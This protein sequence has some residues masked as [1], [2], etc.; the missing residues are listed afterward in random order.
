MTIKTTDEHWVEM[1]TRKE[2][3]WLI[4][5]F[6]GKTPA[7]LYAD[8]KVGKTHMAVNMVAALLDGA[9]TFLDTQAV[10]GPVQCLYVALDRGGE[11]EIT[12][13]LREL[14]SRPALVTGTLDEAELIGAVKAH[15]VGFVV[16]DNVARIL[17]GLNDFND[18]GSIGPLTAL[19][20]NLEDAGASVL[21]IHHTSK[22][23]KETPQSGRS[24]SGTYA[25]MAYF[26]Q[27]IEMTPK[28]ITVKSN[29]HERQTFAIKAEAAGEY[30]VRYLRDGDAPPERRARAPKRR[31]LSTFELRTQAVTAAGASTRADAFAA[32][33]AAE[34]GADEATIKHYVRVKAKKWGLP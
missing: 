15:G 10:N 11:D 14:T 16:L 33:M 30:G 24:P 4:D 5:G 18:P 20:E 13:R 25:L 28:L 26:R 3:T 8:P 7:L 19:I 23:S 21:T 22:P 6:I 2:P 9:A 31:A 27:L 1:Q 17:R 34:P 12:G 32:V 29:A